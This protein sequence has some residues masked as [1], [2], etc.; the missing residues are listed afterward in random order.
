MKRTMLVAGIL[1]ILLILAI[2]LIYIQYRSDLSTTCQELQA[3]SQIAHTL[4]GPIGYAVAG[5]NPAVLVIHGAGG[6]YSQVAAISESLPA[7]R[8]SRRSRC[9]TL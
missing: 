7:P 8:P 6:G 1:L 9:R 3:G 2:G 4:R 5:S